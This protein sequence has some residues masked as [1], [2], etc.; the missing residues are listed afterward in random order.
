MTWSGFATIPKY[1]VGFRVGSRKS[2]DADG[3]VT[4]EHLSEAIEGIN[5]WQTDMFFLR[6]GPPLNPVTLP[7]MLIRRSRMNMNVPY[8]R[9]AM[10]YKP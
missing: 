2:T 1:S 10:A 7:G 8:F 4:L 9:Y 6:A 5:L 3:V